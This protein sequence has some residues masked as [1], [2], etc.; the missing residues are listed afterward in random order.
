MGKNYLICLI[1]IKIILFFLI[2]IVEKDSHQ[3]VI[4]DFEDYFSQSICQFL[5]FAVNYNCSMNFIMNKHFYDDILEINININLLINIK[6]SHLENIFLLLG[7]IPFLKNNSTLFYKINDKGI[8]NFF[9]TILNKRIK[10]KIIKLNYND[11]FI[12]NAK[13]KELLHYKWDY[14]PNKFILDN[15]R[16][17]INNNYNET[18]L[19]IF[20]KTLNI[21]YKSYIQNKINKMANEEKKNLLS[22]FIKL[23]LVIKK[24]ILEYMKK[25]N[26]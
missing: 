24:K 8:Y 12:L 1:Y 19:D 20:Q 22:K 9:K 5:F 3:K 10:Y 13:I 14:I 6:K 18:N 16:Y 15:I 25:I 4:N 2:L 17:I 26:V 23:I 21:N 7:I 11:L